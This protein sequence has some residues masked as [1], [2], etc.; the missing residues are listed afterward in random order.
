MSLQT[1]WSVGQAGPL[2]LRYEVMPVLFD[3]FAIAQS[4][5]RMVFDGVRAMES[6]ALKA[7]HE[8]RR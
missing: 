2:G 4:E 7:L 5:R 3:L 6:E 8:D 1:Q